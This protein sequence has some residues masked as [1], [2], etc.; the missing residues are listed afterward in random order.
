[1]GKL[2]KIRRAMKR[3]PELW[4]TWLI[5]AYFGVELRPNGKRVGNVRPV[6]TT[7]SYRGYVQKMRREM[8]GAG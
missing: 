4:N 7:T 6:W 2:H 8:F 1:M 3:N 5:G